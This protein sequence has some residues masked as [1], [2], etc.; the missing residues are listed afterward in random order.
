[1]VGTGQAFTWATL[2]GSK[3]TYALGS[4]KM[5]QGAD[6]RTLKMTFL[7]ANPKEVLQYVCV[8]VFNLHAC[9]FCSIASILIALPQLAP[10]VDS[11]HNIPPSPIGRLG[12]LGCL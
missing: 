7:W 10:G 1:M 5:A 3:E 9:S 2:S 12:Y 11:I 6:G 8:F 4:D